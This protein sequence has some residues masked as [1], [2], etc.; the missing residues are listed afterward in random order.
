MEPT[1][2]PIDSVIESSS[3]DGKI[4]PKPRGKVSRPLATRAP[5]ATHEPGSHPANALTA[6]ADGRSIA[7][8]GPGGAGIP[9][10]RRLADSV[11]ARRPMLAQGFAGMRFAL[12]VYLATRLL[13]IVVASI[14][15][16]LRG[17]PFLNELTNWDGFWY[18]SVANIGYPGYVSHWQT[19]LGFFPLYPLSMKALS[20][21]FFWAPYGRIGAITV[22]GLFIS[23]IGGFVTAVLVQRMASE[24]WDAAA[25]RRAVLLFCLFPGSVI[26]SMVYAEGLAIPL[27][28]GCIYALS[29]RRWVLAGLLAGINTAVEPEAFVLIVVCAVSALLE[30]R[31]QGWSIRA[32]APSFAAPFLSVFGGL[33][34]GAYLWGHTGSPFASFIAQRDGWGEH[35]N[36]LAL[37]HDATKLSSQWTWSNLAEPNVNLNLVVGLVGAVLMLAMIVLMFIQRRRV[38]IEA[39]LWS[40]GIAFLTLTSANIP[41][42]PRL[43]ITAFPLL[44]VAA[45][46]IRGWWFKALLVVNGGLLAGLSALTF[47]GL[48]LRP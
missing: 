18:R 44:M 2:Q 26:F 42:N 43:L 24:W 27:A 35:T 9:P 34:F 20:Y 6:L 33:S 16:P 19:N 46:Y 8:P 21:V 13:L 36:L 5:A 3:D 7:L 48:T 17:W 14:N 40:L 39:I 38:P 28:A 32:A 29:H 31:R 22:A 12:G 15:G 11:A 41:P 4:T 10:L 25:G 23:L 30:L 47:V 1:S 37:V 45:Y